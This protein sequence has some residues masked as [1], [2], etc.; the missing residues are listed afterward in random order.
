[1]VKRGT[2]HREVLTQ[3]AV[4][5]VYFLAAWLSLRIAIV[6]GQV[7]P[8]W[9]PTAIGVF[10]LYTFGNRF[11]VGVLIGAALASASTGAPWGFIALS[12]LGNTSEAVIGAL[13]LR[14]SGFEPALGR[15]NDVVSLYR[16]TLPAVL[17]S[18]VT[19]TF[20]MWSLGMVATSVV[21]T[22]FGVWALGN[23]MGALLLSPVLFAFSAR[24]MPLAETTSPPWLQR[25]GL[26]AALIGISGV[27]FGVPLTKDGTLY[28]QAFLLFPPVLWAA[29]RVG[30]RGAAL[31]TL[32]VSALAIVGTAMGHGPFAEQI[33]VE[34][35]VVLQFFLAVLL[36]TSLLLAASF[37]ER[38]AASNQRVLSERLASVGL[39]AA[40]VGHEIKNPLAFVSLS[41][42]VAA[43]ELE[44]LGPF[45]TG[46]VDV[47]R[48]KAALADA[49]HG[50]ERIGEI[51]RSL[52]LLAREAA[53]ERRALRLESLVPLTLPLVRHELRGRVE[54]ETVFA[55]SPRVLGNEA[56]LGQV[57]LNLVLN[58]IQAIP[59]SREGTIRI[60]TG[61]DE[62]GRGFLEVQDDGIGMSATEVR[63]LFQ[64]FFTTRPAGVGTGLGLYVSR[65][66]IREHG[67]EVSVRTNLGQGTTFRISLPP[68]PADARP[69]SEPSIGVVPPPVKAIELREPPAVSPGAEAMAM[70]A[71]KRPRV[72]IVDDEVRLGA[73]MRL[74]LEPDHEVSAIT[75]GADALSRLLGGERYDVVLCDL[76]MPG[77]TG[78]DVYARLRRD[79]PEQAGRVVFLTGGAWSAEARAFVADVP[80][81]VLEKPVPPAELLAAVGRMAR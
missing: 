36:T 69:I 78:M 80:N 62:G 5:A 49:R 22:V 66:I 61:T 43:R 25:I 11:S 47:E 17:A 14:R 24:P 37:A 16:A 56:R 71:A 38:Q 12:A 45:G 54:I 27:V 53:E 64:P 77:L 26:A 59:A 8:V 41:L 74:L 28:A 46:V 57:L 63:H 10:A 9:F 67:G 6:S 3:A 1:M 51:A 79:A 13:V 60:S 39:L 33:V 70:A 15:V 52:K 34:G 72:L 65:E 32:T 19:G 44:R 50:T 18:A 76:Q 55:P 31:A 48:A 23:F 30:P 35:V 21:P 58:A 73:S 81:P 20:A 68:A 4:A 75:S 7:S 42:E 2:L 29:L 40:G